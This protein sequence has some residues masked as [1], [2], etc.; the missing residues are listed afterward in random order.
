MLPG[1]IFNITLPSVAYVT[2][3]REVTIVVFPEWFQLVR[4]GKTGFNCTTCRGMKNFIRN[5]MEDSS[6]FTQLM[7]EWK[8]KRGEDDPAE[9]VPYEEDE[10]YEDCV[11][12]TSDNGEKIRDEIKAN[13][14]LLAS[15]N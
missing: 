14:S 4:D 12:V 10:D 1:K 13:S 15:N 6:K 8:L 5:K 7:P 2:G 3:K 11:S 9:P